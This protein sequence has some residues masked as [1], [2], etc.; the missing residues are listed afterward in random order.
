MKKENE[1]I[2]SSA[3][4]LLEGT[5]VAFNAFRSGIFSV[6]LGDSSE[7]SEE[8]DYN[9]KTLT[10]SRLASSSLLDSLP[11]DIPKILHH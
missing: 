8:S 6:T 2:H 7:K 3:S 9:N 11:S 4:T 5:E 1:S 10:E